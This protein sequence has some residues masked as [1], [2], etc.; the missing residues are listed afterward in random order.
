M[1]RRR[2]RR[3]VTLGLV[4]VNGSSRT[5]SLVSAAVIAC[6]LCASC[7]RRQASAD[8]PLV[9]EEQAFPNLSTLHVADPRAEPQ[10][11]RGW[12]SI[13]QGTFRWTEKRFAVALKTPAVGKPATLE[14][15]FVLPDALMARLHSVTV[16]AS[17]QGAALPGQTYTKAGDQ[18]YRVEVPGAALQESIVRIDFLLDKALP[19][20]ERDRRELGVAAVSVGLK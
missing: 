3:S 16:S 13:E 8:A 5:R 20:D 2:G 12:H 14:L 17:I 7:S 19:P 9:E 18:V 10:L 11:L 1:T 6:L 4:G 15:R